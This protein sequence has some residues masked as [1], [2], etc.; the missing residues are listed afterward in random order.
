[1]NPPPPEPSTSERPEV[2]A[3]SSR[4]PSLKLS[5]QQTATHPLKSSR[6]ETLPPSII[7]G[8]R[9]PSPPRYS[10]SNFDYRSLPEDYPGPRVSHFRKSPLDRGGHRGADRYNQGYSRDTGYR[11]HEYGR[12]DD[13][14][15]QGYGPEYDYRDTSYDDRERYGRDAYAMDDYE[16]RKNLDRRDDHGNGNDNRSRMY[17]GQSPF[18]RH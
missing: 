15:R 8:Q 6:D 13:D 12:Y 11:D 1:L 7:S 16:R 18:D 14:V 5:G 17:S 9:P 4:H 2:G 3:N 10:S